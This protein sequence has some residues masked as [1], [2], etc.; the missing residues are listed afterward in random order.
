MG[1]V[2]C[3]PTPVDFDGDVTLFHFVLLRCVGKG[4]FGKVRVV[5]HKQTRELYALKYIN[6]A[7]C[8]KMK[9]VPNVIQERRL[10]EEVCPALESVFSSLKVIQI[11][12]PYVAATMFEIRPPVHL[13][14]LGSLDEEVVRFYVAQLSSAIQFLHDMNIMHRDIKPDNILLDERGNAHL[15]DFNI[16]LKFSE[17]K[18]MGVAGSMAYM[19]PE[20]VRSPTP[21]FHAAN[22]VGEFWLNVDTIIKSTGGHLVITKD[23]LKW[24]EDAEKKCSRP[25]M[26]VLKGLL[27]RDVTRR[28][29]CKPHSEGY[30]ELQ[31]HPWFKSIDWD[32]LDSKEQTSPFVPDA[33]KANFDASHELEELLLEDNPLKA[34]TRKANQENFSPEMR[35]MEDQFTTYDFKKMQRRSY[36]PH[37]QLISTAT[38]TSSGMASSRPG[39]PANDLRVENGI[40]INGNSMDLDP[41]A[42]FNNW[43]DR[44]RSQFSPLPEGTTAAVF[45]LLFP[46]QD[47]AFR[48]DMQEKR[49]ASALAACYGFPEDN[50]TAWMSE[51]SL[52]CLGDDLRKSLTR[53]DSKPCDYVG[54]LSI[55]QVVDLLEELASHSGYSDA[56]VRSKYPTGSRRRDK[57]TIIR[58]L[59]RELP[60]MDAAFLAQIILK[61][62]RPLLYPLTETHYT[63]ALKSFNTLSVTALTQEHAMK[64]WDPS[65]RMCDIYRVR[66]RLVDA[67]TGFEAGLSSLTPEIG[68]PIQMPKSEKGR[69][70]LHVLERLQN[71]TEI[72]AETKYDGER[73]QIHVKIRP[74]KRAHIQIF[75]KSKRDST[76]DRHAIH[77]VIR[78]ALQ[79][80]QE[81]SCVQRDVIL[82]AEM[83]PWHEGQID[84][85]WRINGL[86]EA[87]AK[88]VRRR[89]S[90]SL[91]EEDLSQLSLVTDNSDRQLGLV[92]FDILMLN[93]KSLM[94][95]S[96][97]ARR[98]ILE[99]VI[100]PIPGLAILA[101]RWPIGLHWGN[102]QGHP[103]LHHVFAECLAAAKEGLV[104]KA[105]ESGYNDRRLPWV[106]LKKDYIPGYGDCLDMVV[107]GVSWE[108]ERGREFRV[109]PGTYTTF[110]IGGLLKDRGRSE[111]PVFGIYFTASY[112]LGRDQLED[113]NFRIKSSDP[114]PFKSL[115]GS[116]SLPGYDFQL[117]AGLT[118][119]MALL[120]EPLLCEL[121][122]AGFSK[123][124][125]SRHYALRFP[126][127]TKIY[128]AQERSWKEGVTLP[129]LHKIARTAVGKTAAAADE[130]WGKSEDETRKRKRA[131]AQ[132]ED[133]LFA[134]D[135][136]AAHR[137]QWSLLHRRILGTFQSSH[138]TIVT[139][140]SH[141]PLADISNSPTTETFSDATL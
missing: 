25:G 60:T 10:L 74:D 31:R 3:R 129:N 85:F 90:K 122:G 109:A 124:P 111:K 70:C 42:T 113:V 92:V 40:S 131:S 137:K 38:A 5:Q 107:L 20:C 8:V 86:V 53:T 55:Q 52:G 112:G 28:F 75:S 141:A 69:S 49:L 58:K 140:T 103:S 34:K 98:D 21:T 19:A 37:N 66:S 80:D 115:N 6:K 81:R 32:T 130:I 95:E 17:R 133:R 123:S 48:Y 65:R 104:L 128:R 127:I 50:L 84:E 100:K 138:Q 4:A 89:E 1:G 13:E 14:R 77:D 134:D 101:D 35:Q 64:A 47:V 139:G 94:R 36:F 96:Y 23:P 46:E 57:N 15:T 118:P 2:C 125:H 62:L 126:R 18:L 61:D 102:R 110:F 117:H 83:V 12:H 87:T 121:L 51:T 63:A 7:K 82:D 135:R 132:W 136:R 24:P 88:G 71:S 99:S 16:G 91:I 29:G 45:R 105:G 43:I 41:L 78:Q 93:S 72:W 108:K 79:L 119:P 97:S 76:W 27:D 39:T 30:H 22:D 11:D 56:D 67:A 44:L 114:I 26:Q 73:A 54:P 9:A 68:V 59:F 120:R 33:K 106:K 116:G